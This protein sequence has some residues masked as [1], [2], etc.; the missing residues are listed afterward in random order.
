MRPSPAGPSQKP[1]KKLSQK[2]SRKPS[3]NPS[4]KPSQKPS[5]KPS[6]RPSNKPSPKPSKKPSQMPSRKPSQNPSEKPSQKP[7]KEHY[8]YSQSTHTFSGIDINTD[9]A[10]SGKI[11][12]GC[13]NKTKCRDEPACQCKKNCGP[14]PEGKYTIVKTKRWHTSLYP[15]DGEVCTVCYRLEPQ[16]ETKMCGRDGFVIHGG[17]CTEKCTVGICDKKE[18]TT[19]CIVIENVV[20]REKIKDGATLEVVA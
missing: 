1:S 5:K 11:Y 15:P 10:C 12:D 16:D 7:S 14:I 6:P 19:G 18:P 4:E 13:P 20:I 9:K 2:P 8:T 3:Q 17:S